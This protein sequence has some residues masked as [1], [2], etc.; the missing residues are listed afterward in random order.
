MSNT[1]FK[2]IREY[3][4]VENKTFTIPNYQRG[5]KWSVK[6]N[7]ENSAVEDLCDDLIKA[8]KE[9][10]YFLQGITVSEHHDKIIL[11]DGQQRTTTLY[12]ILWYLNVD[13]FKNI[14]LDYDIREKSKRYLRGLLDINFDYLNFDKEDSNQD[15]FY[16]KQAI[17]Q[18]QFK[19]SQ[20]EDIETFKEF[21]LNKVCILYIVISKEKATKTFS[22]MNG[23][24]ATMLQEELIKSEILRQ[25]SIPKI[26]SKQSATSIDDKLE[27]LKN[28]ISSDWVINAKRSRYSREWDRW[29]YWWNDEDI[30]AYFN[31]EKP[32]GYLLQFY[33][34]KENKK[35][36]EASFSQFK[37]LL[38]KKTAIQIFKELRDLQKSFEDLINSPK[39]YNCL[40]L[41]LLCS[42][43]HIDVFDILDFFFQNRNSEQELWDYAKW[44]LVGATH[45][46]TTK[47][48][49]PG[50]EEETKEQKAII[51]FNNLSSKFV[52]SNHNDIALKQLLRLNVEEE[53]RLFNGK[54]RKFD[55]SIY[56][57]KSLEHIHPKS[58][59]YHQIIGDKIDKS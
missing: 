1:V 26:S 51:A 58:K 4:S 32:L 35:D 23:A 28:I 39:I 19:L 55:F 9:A 20:I 38:Q 42:S 17:K 14:Q 25:I 7:G 46:Q 6:I 59:V 44:R 33:F 5:Y 40:K 50:I 47:F 27:E 56:S 49:E 41:S 37:K 10:T 11:I 22:M 30:Q 12:L 13:L 15:I 36:R 24:K 48:G 29:L 21:I 52:Y 3:L 16:F 53:N 2:N 43:G 8:P 31:V 45:R 57:N 18:I 54:G 34:H